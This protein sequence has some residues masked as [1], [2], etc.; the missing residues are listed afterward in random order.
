MVS[1]RYDEIDVSKWNTNHIHVYLADEHEKRFGVP[2]SPF[3]SYKTEKGMIGKIIGTARKPGEYSPEILKCFVDECFATYRPNREYPGTSF[4][5][6]WTYRQNV[7]QRLVAEERRKAN[8]VKTDDTE[9]E[10]VDD[11]I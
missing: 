10:G 1:K 11:W 7:W 2:Y 3:K 5:F 4:G 8:V 6:C 9:W